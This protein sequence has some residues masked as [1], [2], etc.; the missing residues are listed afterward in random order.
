MVSR[1]DNLDF[2]TMR[3]GLCTA[4]MAGGFAY[5]HIENYTGRNTILYDEYLVDLGQ[6]AGPPVELHIDLVDQADFETGVPPQFTTTCGSGDGTWTTD[7]ALV[8]DGAGSLLGRASLEG[9]VWQ[10]F[11]CTDPGDIALAPGSSYTI[12]FNYRVVSAPPGDCYFYAVARSDA[13]LNNSNRLAV[14]FDPPAGTV[15]QLRAEV[16][17]GF[18]P[19]YYFLWGLKNGGSVVIDSIRIM[20]GRGGAFRR[21]FDGGIALVNATAAPITLPIEPGFHRIAGTVDPITNN[22]A[23]VSQVVLAPT[24]GLVLLAGPATTEPGN[25]EVPEA[26]SIPPARV[27]AYPNPVRISTAPAV[28]IAG[29]PAGGSVAVVT[30]GGR[31]VATLSAA[32]PDGLWRWD[33]RSGHARTVAPGVYLAVVR[34]AEHGVVRTLRLALH[35]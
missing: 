11:L 21:D 34:D 29:V 10:L 27:F 25:P 14:I 26:P 13:D 6:P 19:S 15:G 2:R 1:T 4:L 22:G 12:T 9:G 23:E 8:I 3:Y 33:F 5:H 18:Y 20:R 35:R 17:L 32:D 31:T 28:Q 7:P 30:P 16:T 24:D